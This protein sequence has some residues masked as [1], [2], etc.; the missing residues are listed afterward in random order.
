[1]HLKCTRFPCTQSLEGMADI[2]GACIAANVQL[3][4]GTMWTH[5]P[6]ARV[7]EKIL[8]DAAAFGTV[9]SVHANFTFKGTASA[10]RAS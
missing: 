6:R 4:D 8:K 2:M 7:I 1:M 3:M 10:P 5:N 9:A